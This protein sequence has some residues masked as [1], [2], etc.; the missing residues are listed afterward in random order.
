MEQQV[1]LSEKLY[2]TVGEAAK[3]S[4]IGECTIRNLARE[5]NCPF[6]LLVGRKVMIHR[7]K[8]EE[9]LAQQTQI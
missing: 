5:E 1:N 2:L 6:V 9:Y 3:Y 7:A 4:G 8:F